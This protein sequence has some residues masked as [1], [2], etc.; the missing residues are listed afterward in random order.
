MWVIREASLPLSPA[1]MNIRNKAEDGKR[2]NRSKKGNNSRRNLRRT[3]GGFNENRNVLCNERDCKRKWIH[4]KKRERS[5]EIK[6]SHDLLTLLISLGPLNLFP[7]LFVWINGWINNIWTVINVRDEASRCIK[8]V[9]AEKSF[10]VILSFTPFLC[11]V[12]PH[13]KQSG[14]HPSMHWTNKNSS[15]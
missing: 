5:N 1:Q 15:T 7:Y 2:E 11:T 14:W 10:V 4:T 8:F 6:G 12:L 9:T 13:S 3:M